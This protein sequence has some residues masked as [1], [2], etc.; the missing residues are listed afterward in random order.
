MSKER[1]RILDMLSQG[2]INSDEAEKLL[3]A[4]NINH[5]SQNDKNV[6]NDFVKNKAKFLVVKVEKPDGHKNQNVDIKIPLALL[7]AGMKL[8]SLV[9]SKFNEK[10]NSHFTEHGLDFNLNDINSENLSSFISALQESPIII[11]ADKEKVEIA[12]I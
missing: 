5:F 9:P 12:C 8:K 6:P 7:K 2:K 11:D 1:R 3:D 10:F 4:L